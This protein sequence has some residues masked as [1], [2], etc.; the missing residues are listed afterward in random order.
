MLHCI[1]LVICVAANIYRHCHERLPGGEECVEDEHI[2]MCQ[3]FTDLCN[4]ATTSFTASA[5]LLLLLLLL[6]LVTSVQIVL[7][8]IM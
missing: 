4:V 6:L 1:T 2:V 8:N 5:A 7:L 3:C